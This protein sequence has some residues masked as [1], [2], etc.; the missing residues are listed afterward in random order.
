MFTQKLPNSKE[1]DHLKSAQ[2]D[3]FAKV[4]ALLFNDIS[5]KFKAYPSMDMT[6]LLEQKRKTYSAL[7]K[8]F[9]DEAVQSAISASDASHT[10]PTVDS[11]DVRDCFQIPA[12]VKVVQPLK[13]T[14]LQAVQTGSFSGQTDPDSSAIIG[15]L[16]RLLASCEIVW[17]LGSTAVLGLNS[18]LIVK[19]GYDI[20]INHIHTL[21][22][23]KQQAPDTPIP[24]IHGILQQSDSKRIFLFM[25][26][27][28][29]EPLDSK[30]RLLNTDQK[31]S[32]KVQLG[33]IVKNFR[34]IPAPPAEEANAVL[35][36]GNPRRCKD[37][38]RQ[39]RIAT[40][41]ISNEIEFNQ[42]LV[43]NSTRSE[44]DGIAMIKSYLDTNHKIVMTHGDLHPRNIMVTINPRSSDRDGG[45]ASFQKALDTT[46]GTSDLS[47]SQVTVTG[48]LDWEMCGWYPEY[49]EYVKALNTITIGGDFGDWWSYLPDNIGVWPKEHAVD[50][51][52]SRWH[53]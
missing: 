17:H 4:N 14:V 32:I 21:D 35:G 48:I 16:N 19:V 5:A 43:S 28:P 34:S 36:G 41:P 52:L 49:W 42:F 44:C 12:D 29:G 18:E 37:T 47:N 51:M 31:T 23:I 30:W 8:A 10:E 15:G 40:G 46:T 1:T 6:A 25:S 24:E 45:E 11:P 53:G 22:Y 7:R 27:L 20:D 50:V 26:R 38:R 9:G 13:K 39:V 3:A 33:A 2:E